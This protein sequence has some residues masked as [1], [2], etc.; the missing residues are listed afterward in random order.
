MERDYISFAPIEPQKGKNSNLNEDQM[1]DDYNED[2]R[3]ITGQLK[4]YIAEIFSYS[5]SSFIN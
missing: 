5:K 4:Y 1:N 3:N 2:Q